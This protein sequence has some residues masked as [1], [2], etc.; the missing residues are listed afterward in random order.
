MSRKFPAVTAKQL[1]RVIKKIGFVYYRS[2][3]GSHE[4]Y[5]RESDHRI[6]MVS[7]HAGEI[8]RRKTLSNIL[9]AAG[10][11]PEKFRELL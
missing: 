6:V 9:E 8:I 10:L 5:I 4:F 1:V 3:K 7:R 11:T 2:G